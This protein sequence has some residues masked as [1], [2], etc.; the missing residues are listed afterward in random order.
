MRTPLLEQLA[1]VT[2]KYR[3]AALKKHPG[4]DGIGAEIDADQLANFM[5]MLLIE[6]ELA[7]RF[8]QCMADS[9]EQC[10]PT[11]STSAAARGAS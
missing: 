4:I 7:R 5:A 8:V 6:P 2:N 11:E 1:D 3:A 10:Y 9:E